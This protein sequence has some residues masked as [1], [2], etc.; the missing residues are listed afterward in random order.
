MRAVEDESGVEL[1]RKRAFVRF[2]RVWFLHVRT[3]G[4]L[5]E[6]PAC[7][8]DGAGAE[9]GDRAGEEL[10]SVELAHGL[11]CSFGGR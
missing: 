3:R 5:R 11:A 8:A 7:H 6:R 9:E 2:G 1:A 10:A 4:R